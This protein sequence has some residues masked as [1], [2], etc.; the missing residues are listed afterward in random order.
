MTHPFAFYDTVRHILALDMELTVTGFMYREA[1]EI[2]VE[3]GYWANGD[4][5]AVWLSLGSLELVR[6]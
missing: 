1:G 6:K 5:K 4:Y 2:Q 3:C